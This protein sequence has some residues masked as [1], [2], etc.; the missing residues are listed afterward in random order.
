MPKPR[1]SAT[2]PST[3][4]D[5]P[6]AWAAYRRMW[7]VLRDTQLSR[8]PEPV[9][10]Q[11]RHARAIVAVHAYVCRL[12]MWGDV[13][14]VEEAAH[15]WTWLIEQAVIRWERKQQKEVQRQAAA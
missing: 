1:P 4:P 6:T 2:A 7:D 15:V 8:V 5:P 10:W 12:A 3:P 13:A 14:L 11:I 9:Q